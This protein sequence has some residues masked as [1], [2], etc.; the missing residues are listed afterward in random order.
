MVLHVAGCSA[1]TPAKTARPA[2]APGTPPP[3]TPA[4]SEVQQDKR[5]DD[6]KAIE[7]ASHGSKP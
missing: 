3:Q 2:S 4:W 5:A 1:K 6:A 7:A